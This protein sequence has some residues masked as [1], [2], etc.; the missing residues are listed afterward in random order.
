MNKEEWLKKGYVTD[1]AV[2]DVVV[3]F[4]ITLELL[5]RK[6]YRTKEAISGCRRIGISVMQ[7]ICGQIVR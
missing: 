7:R 2:T 1:S 4:T 3:T 5:C 6:D